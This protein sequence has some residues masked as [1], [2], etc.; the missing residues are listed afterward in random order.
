MDSAGQSPVKF[1][2]NLRTR[3]VSALVLA[4]ATV[5]VVWQGGLVFQIVTGLVVGIGAMELFK[6]AEKRQALVWAGVLYLLISLLSFWWMRGLPLGWELA[7]Y[8]MLCVWA[9]D[10]GAYFSGRFI[11]GA[12]LAPAISPSKTW[13]GLFGG[14]AFAA[15]TGT[16][17]ALALGA[18]QPLVIGFWGAILAVVAQAGDLLE[19]ALKRAVGAKDSGSIIPGHGGILDRID[20]LLLA[21][22]FFALLLTLW[23]EKFLGW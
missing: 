3:V 6:I 17:L 22:P 15:V 11:G 12:R 13:A 4:P 16:L 18:H 20:G 23:S 5:W 2:P 9:T 8:L 19:S 7:I 21:A 10:V 14:M 1:G